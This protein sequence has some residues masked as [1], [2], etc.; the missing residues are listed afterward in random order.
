MNFLS[1]NF[2]LRDRVRSG[3]QGTARFLN[4]SVF[5]FRY[6]LQAPPFKQTCALLNALPFLKYGTASS[7]QRKQ[8]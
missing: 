1:G 6:G 5:S 3:F 8:N 2:D 7:A 4:F